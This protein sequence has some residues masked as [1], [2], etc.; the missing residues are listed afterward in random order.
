MT[1]REIARY[2]ALQHS[3]ELVEGRVNWAREDIDILKQFYLEELKLL[4][5]SDED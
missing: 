1:I 3:Q 4:L 5:V 2:M